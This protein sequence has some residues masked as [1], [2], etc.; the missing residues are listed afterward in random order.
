MCCCFVPGL[1]VTQKFNMNKT[2]QSRIRVAFKRFTPSNTGLDK[3]SQ[4]PELSTTFKA[5]FCK[6]A[7]WFFAMVALEIS[8][9]NPEESRSHS[10]IFC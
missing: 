9:A 10:S 2:L 3:A 5:A 1:I 6:S 4:Y 8:Q 7:L